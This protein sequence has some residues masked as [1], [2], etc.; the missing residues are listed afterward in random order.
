MKLKDIYNTSISSL[1]SQKTRSVL[2]ILGISIGI[3]IVITIMSAGKG[4]DKYLVSQLEVFGSDTVWTEVKV[5]STK[6]TSTENASGQATGITITTMKNK[7]IDSIRKLNNI[8]AVYGWLM[9]QESVTY[10]NESRRMMLMGQGY[11][12]PQVEKFEID[13][14]RFYTKE[15]EDSSSAV[16]VLG[17]TAKNKLFGDDNPIDKTI[18][19][20][21]KPF[22]VIGLAKERGSAFFMDMD[23]LIILPTKTLQKR[24]IGNDYVSAIASK[25]I[26]LNKLDSTVKEIEYTMRYNHNITDPDKDDFAVSTMEE[27]RD[28]LGT[29]VDGITFLLVAL[30]CISLVVGGV[31]IM[32]I[33]YVS[34]IERTF[35]IGLRK[36]LGAKKRDISK[37]FLFEAVI[38]TLAGGVV[39]IIFGAILSFIVYLVANYYHLTWVYIIPISAVILAVLFSVAVGLFFGLY[40]A[41]KAANLNPI[42]ALRK[43]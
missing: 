29:V 33:M 37:Q 12:M 5:P 3:A 28:M 25:V 4:L 17:Y 2:T 11:Q 24:I 30:V 19:I 36:A 18:Y 1:R 40:P 32:N 41:R 43:E 27:A 8:K 10:Q 9:G 13:K 31:G 21:H 26:D 34:V 42:E 39:G 6:K 7:D 38:L 22:K 16:V 23:N 20:K 35:E 14:G 15:E